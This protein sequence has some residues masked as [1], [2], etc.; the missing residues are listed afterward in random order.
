MKKT[1]VLVLGATL[2]A[3]GLLA[4]CGEEDQA[5]AVAIAAPAPVVVPAPVV[6]AAP[7]VLPPAVVLPAADPWDPS[8]ATATITIK[9][10]V[11]GTPPRMR[12][13]KFDADPKCGEQHAEAVPDQAVVAKD[14]K[15]ANVIAWVSKGAEKWSFT[16]PAEAAVIDQKG[17]LYVP[18]VL[19]VMVN[20][21]VTIRNSDPVMHNI[22]AVPKTNA[23]FNKSQLKGAGDI[24]EKFAREEVAVKIKCDVHGWMLAWAG[25]FSHSLHGVTG[26]DGTVSIKVPPGEY[27]VSGWHEYAKWESRPTEAVKVTVAAGETKDVEFVFTAAEKK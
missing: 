12:P 4:G 24:T 19:T 22:H 27:E 23:E 1:T 14:G 6:E 7:A 3:S 17:C 9:A 21:P 2:A 10:T 16:A 26:A 13:V 5:V 18:H 11:K 25:V 20:Q 15:L 8:K